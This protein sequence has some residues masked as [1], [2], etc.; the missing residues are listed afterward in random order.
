MIQNANLSN[1]SKTSF[2]FK[3]TTDCQRQS[4]QQPISIPLSLLERLSSAFTGCS[5]NQDSNLESASLRNELKQLND[6]T[7]LN[8]DQD[9]SQ[10]SLDMVSTTL[11]QV[12][13]ALETSPCLP[14]GPFAAHQPCMASN[15]TQDRACN[16]RNDSRVALSLP[17]FC[18]SG[19][20]MTIVKG[21]L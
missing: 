15:Q 6:K 5:G 4:T 9:S 2:I 7:V 17:V 16:T 11:R 20:T 3:V 12:T 14:R 21:T 19:T 13:I 18:T 1:D 8:H 10:I